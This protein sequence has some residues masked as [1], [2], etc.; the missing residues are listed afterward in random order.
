M[1]AH[2]LL[3]ANT[4]ADVSLAKLYGSKW[5]CTQCL[6]SALPDDELLHLPIVYVLR[7][8]LPS[9]SHAL[10]GRLAVVV[11]PLHGPFRVGQ[12]NVAQSIIDQSA[13]KLLRLCLWRGSGSVAQGEQGAQDHGAM[14]CQPSAID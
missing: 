5:L 12:A 11:S 13:V 2:A 9:L 14:V 8:M 4:A 1:R 10:C 7:P 3:G 6:V